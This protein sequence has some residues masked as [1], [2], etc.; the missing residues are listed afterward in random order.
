MALVK[1]L[2]IATTSMLFL[3]VEVVFLIVIPLMQGS[4]FEVGTQQYIALAVPVAIITI[5]GAL[6]IFWIGYTMIT[7]PEPVLLTYEEAY[8]AASA[9]AVNE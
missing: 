6:S 5:V 1:G 3:V 9:E 2:V 8:E 4:E 7:T